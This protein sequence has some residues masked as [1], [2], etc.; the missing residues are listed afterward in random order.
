M[1]LTVRRGLITLDFAA[2]GKEVIEIDTDDPDSLYMTNFERFGETV[3]RWKKDRM[4][5]I[6]Y[7]KPTIQSIFRDWVRTHRAEIEGLL[8]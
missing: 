3:D 2:E 6:K 7:D 8:K 1:K 4:I 5:T